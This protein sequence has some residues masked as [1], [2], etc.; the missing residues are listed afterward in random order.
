M[1]VFLVQHVHE[2]DED[3]EDVKLIGV[4]A[5]EEG[6]QAAVKRLSI[7][8]GFRDTT[9]GFHIDRYRVDEDHWTEGFVTVPRE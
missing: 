5:T 1:D 9:D 8:P 3:R 6:A 7:Q 2:L 4:Y